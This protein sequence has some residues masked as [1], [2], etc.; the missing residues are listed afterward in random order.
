MDE[1]VP[2]S[3]GPYVNHIDLPKDKQFDL[4]LIPMS[5]KPFHI[6]HEFL[7]NRAANDCSHVIVFVSIKDR[8]RKGELKIL[9]KH[10]KDIWDEHLIKVMPQ[11]VTIQFS[12]GSPIKDAY[13]KLSDLK[14][15]SIKIATY[16]DSN[17]A[18][19]YDY[20]NARCISFL[21]DVDSPQISGKEMRE[22]ILKNDFDK[23]N[24]YSHTKL[25]KNQNKMIF[26]KL[27]NKSEFI[28]VF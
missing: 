2:Q 7:I 10:M 3:H 23:F 21:R 24:L 5:A 19:N 9:G 15:S 1:T 12:A 22:F 28:K 25:T 11:N 8:E 16:S 14:D 27:Q 6:G 20:E 18:L 4:G 13:Q 17:D 26:N